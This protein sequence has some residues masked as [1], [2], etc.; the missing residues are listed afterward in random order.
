MK[1]PT[2]DM[3]LKEHD[4]D[5]WPW[6]QNNNLHRHRITIV[7][8]RIMIVS[9]PEPLTWGSAILVA[10]CGKAEKHSKFIV[11]HW[12][13]RTYSRCLAS[14]LKKVNSRTEH[15][16]QWLEQKIKWSMYCSSQTKIHQSK[17]TSRGE[18]ATTQKCRLLSLCSQVKVLEPK[19]MPMTHI[20]LQAIAIQTA[21]AGSST[22]GT[23]WRG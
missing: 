1:L 15:T 23:K 18:L 16:P 21:G 3:L 20:M 2:C 11:H 22:W 12:H 10:S 14:L 6:H 4:R 5:G 13:H 8:R 7:W 17:P 9:M 19:S